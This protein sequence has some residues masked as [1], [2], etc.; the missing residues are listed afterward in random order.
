[1]VRPA[2]R[3]LFSKLQQP[4]R[5]RLARTTAVTPVVQAVMLAGLLLTCLLLAGCGSDTTEPAAV[6]P[7][8]HL[9]DMTGCK[10]QDL[11]GADEAAVGID[12]IKY[13]YR[14]C[15]LD[16]KH[17]NAAFNCCPEVDASVTV[18]GDTILVVEE[19]R[20]G[21]CHCL[22]LYDLE[23][24]LQGLPLGVYRVIVSEEYLLETDDPLEFTIDLRV[25]ASGQHC[26]T[27]DHYP[28]AE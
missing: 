19:E 17:I 15:T 18:S 5:Y 22:C 13:S 10:S 12:C 4:A 11:L 24:E 23:Y 16:L 9:V 28:W 26:A 21:E 8:G 1:M 20:V 7:I 2:P 14:L 3:F 6:G 27:R 25:S